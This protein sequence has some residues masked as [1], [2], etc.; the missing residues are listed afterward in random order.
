[1]QKVHTMAPSRDSIA[2]WPPLSTVE[3]IPKVGFVPRQLSI[4]RAY[5]I[6]NRLNLG[7]S[8]RQCH[9]HT[10]GQS[11]QSAGHRVFRRD[12]CGRQTSWRTL[13]E[14]FT[15]R[16]PFRKG[17]RK[18]RFRWTPLSNVRFVNQNTGIDVGNVI[19]GV[20]LVL[21]TLGAAL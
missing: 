3:T 9:N 21:T 16:L 17:C 14:T 2:A 18:T 15:K 6:G 5:S 7:G 20:N 1:M 19:R 11:S 4:Q 12:W 8:Q 10:E 13:S